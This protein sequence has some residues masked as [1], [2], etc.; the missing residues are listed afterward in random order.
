[1]YRLKG[2]LKFQCT[3]GYSFEFFGAMNDAISTVKLHIESFHKSDLPFGITNEEARMLVKEEHEPI[4]KRK[5]NSAKTTP[6]YTSK[7]ATIT[8]Q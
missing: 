2:K 5:I 7:N 6:N 4:F 3:C 1:V 8:L